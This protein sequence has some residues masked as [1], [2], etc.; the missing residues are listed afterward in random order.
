MNNKL[1]KSYLV[2]A[3]AVSASALL[4][5]YVI[6]V[7]IEPSN[8]LSSGFTG[9]SILIDRIVALKGGSFSTSLGLIVLNVPVAILCYKAIGKKF[10]ISSLCQ[11][12][13]TSFLLKVLT[14]KPLF[15]DIVLNVCFGGFLYGMSVVCALKGN[16]S[17]AGTDFIA[18]YVSNKK[19]KSVFE[20]V[21]IFNALMLC[22]FGYLFGFLYAGYSIVFQFI[23]TKTISSF[24]RRYK[25]VT[26]QITTK[27]PEK[28]LESY[29]KNYRHGVSVM[30]GYGGYSK[31]HMSLLHTV[32]SYY[33]VSD[34]T[35]LIRNVDPKAIINV[36]NTEE[37]YGGFY[38]RP[39]E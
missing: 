33:E 26:L 3:L 14:F 34:I 27:N 24:Y 23:S 11:V 12:F 21:F 19:G 2:T 4:Q 37:F 1:F 17:T 39:L 30:E 28:V 9:A 8:L 25:R 10:V 29:I 16:S 31:V 5:T 36:L 7:F 15:D 22:V 20:Y 35:M 13:L 38:R 18:L 32:V 6:K